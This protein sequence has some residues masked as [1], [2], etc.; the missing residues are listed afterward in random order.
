MS[1]IVADYKYFFIRKIDRLGDRKTDIFY[2]VSKKSDGQ[3]GM[4]LW[5]GPW[6]AYVLCPDEDTVW[7]IECLKN[8]NEFLEKLKKE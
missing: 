4:I 2:I 8:I 5:Y 3:L 1:E 6:R 7:N